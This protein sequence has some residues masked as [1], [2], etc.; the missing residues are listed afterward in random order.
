ML[1]AS[2]VIAARALPEARIDSAPI[3]A[4]MPFVLIALFMNVPSN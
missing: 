2:T 1:S 4:V 3:P